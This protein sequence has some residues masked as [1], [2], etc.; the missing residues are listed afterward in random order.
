MLQRNNKYVTVFYFIKHYNVTKLLTN[1]ILVENYNKMFN[2]LFYA[3]TGP[4]TF[5]PYV[6]NVFIVYG[7][8]RLS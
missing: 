3:D 5:S 4:Q 1:D 2:L 8:N 6:T 7:C